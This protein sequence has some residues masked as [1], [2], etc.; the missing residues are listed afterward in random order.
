ML[1]VLVAARAVD[2]HELAVVVEVVLDELAGRMT[3]VARR[4]ASSFT[5][6]AGCRMPAAARGDDPLRALVERLQRLASAGSPISTT[7]PLAR[8]GEEAQHAVAHRRRRRAGARS[9]T[10]LEPE[11]GASCARSGCMTALDLL[12]GELD[13]P[14]RRRAGCGSTAAARAAAGEPGSA[15]I[16]SNA[17]RD[18]AL[19]LGQR[20]DP[21][22][23]VAHRRQVAHL[24]EREQ[25]LVLRVLVRDAAE[26]VDVLRPTASRSSAKFSQPP[27][28]HRARPSSGACR[29]A[30][31]PRRAR[32]RS[33]AGM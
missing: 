5:I 12:R 6:S 13:R 32:R 28:F 20:G 25:A 10:M 2:G 1:A 21:P 16:A 8:G 4:G 24:G 29:G 27:Q 33:C 3:R 11:A 26:Q 31:R 23:L 22:V 30:P 18:D 14:A 17:S 7:T 9:W 15:R 19:E